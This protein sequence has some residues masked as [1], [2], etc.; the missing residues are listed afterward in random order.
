MRPMA[1]RHMARPP[2]L[3]HNQLKPEDRTFYP[4]G[5]KPEIPD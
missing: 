3:D 1:T 2:D 5:A 4:Q